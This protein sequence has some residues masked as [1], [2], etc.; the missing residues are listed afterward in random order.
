MKN[1]PGYLTKEKIYA[2][3]KT[4]VYRAIR[5]S[6]QKS[7]I[8]KTLQT[9]YPSFADIKGLKYEYQV[10]HQLN[11][12]GI[13]KVYALEINEK[14]IAI[15][16]EDFN[17]ISLKNFL[18]V[19]S[20]LLNEFLEIAIQLSQA[21]NELHQNK[22]IH[23]DI[24][25]FNIL[26]N[27]K[28]R[29]VKITDF[30][31]AICLKAKTDYHTEVNCPV[32]K[33][34]PAYI[35][36][37]QT[38]KINRPLDYRSDLYSLGITFYELLVGQLPFQTLDPLELI[39]CHISQYPTSPN[40][41]NS[42]VETVISD[43]VMKLIEK[44][45]EDRY[46][47][48]LGLK[49]DLEQCLKQY[50]S[51]GKILN[52]P[53][54]ELDHNSKFL[55]PQK[56]YGR[57]AEIA[58]LLSAFDR[59]RSGR[60]ELMLISGYSGTG[61]TAIVNEAYKSR[62]TNR[63]YFSWGK[64]EKLQRNIPY[65]AI[66]QCFRNL[67]QQILA[68]NLEQINYWKNHFLSFL[69]NNGQIIIDSIPE[70][71]LVIGPQAPALELGSTEAKN[72]F[73]QVFQSFAQAFMEPEHPLILFLDDLQWADLGSIKLIEYLINNSNNKHLLLIGAYRDNE[74]SSLHPFAQMLDSI[75]NQ[76]AIVNHIFLQPLPL[77]SVEQLVNE[78]LSIKN[79]S[80]NELVE[81]IFNKTAGNPFFINQLL[82][83]LYQENCITFNYREGAWQ[84]NIKKIYQIK[85]SDL[86]IIDLIVRNLKSLPKTTQEV[87]ALAS[88]F[89]N[90]F[91]HKNLA[92]IAK[93]REEEIAS[94]LFP[95]IQKCL[96]VPLKESYRS[97]LV[98]EQDI[99]ILSLNNKSIYQFFHDRVQQASYSLIS[100]NER[101]EIHLKIG[102]V[103]LKEN[104]NI[105][106]DESIFEITNQINIG[107]S[108]LDNQEEINELAFLNFTA[109]K[110]AKEATAYEAAKKYLD[111]C[112]NLLLETSWT[113]QY[114]FALKA[115]LLSL[116][117][118]YINADFELANKLLVTLLAFAKSQ[119]DIVQAY[120]FQISYYFTQNHPIKAIE[121]ALEVLK[122]LNINFSK[123]PKRIDILLSIFRVSLA[124]G[125][126]SISE[127]S[128][129]PIMI[130]QDQLMAMR[131]LMAVIPATFVASPKLFP[132]AISKMV[133]ISLKHG[134]S[135][136]SIF[137]YN[138][139]GTL[140]C[141]ALGNFDAGYEYSLVAIDLLEK[142]N[143]LQ[144]KSKV[145]MVFNVFN[146][147][148]KDHLNQ[149]VFML[150]EG[151]SSGLEVGDT[152]YVGHCISFLCI[153]TFLNGD[154]LDSVINTYNKYIRV[155]TE[156]KQ[157]FQEYHSNIWKQVVCN[158][159]NESSKDRL[160]LSGDS[161]SEEY[162]Y[163]KIVNHKNNLVNIAFY[164]AKSFLALLFNEFD[165]VIYF[166][167]FIVDISDD[168]PG[169][170]YIALSNFYFSIS[171]L[172]SSFNGSKMQR[173]KVLKEI[174]VQ[175]QKMKKWANNCPENFMHKYQL[176]EAEKAR[177]LGEK[178]KAIELYD[179]A[180]QS[181]A[182]SGYVQEEAIANERAAEFYFECGN[183]KIGQ[184][185]L[186]DAY[187][188]Y[189]RW[190]A[191]SK[192]KQLEERYPGVL[193][194]L[195]RSSQSTDLT[196]R[197]SVNRTNQI[198]LDL[199]SVLKASQA[200]S[201][202]IVLDELL[203]KLLKVLMQSAGAQTVVLILL[204]DQ[205]FTIEASATVHV[206]SVHESIPLASSDQVPQSVINFV[207]RTQQPIVL[208]EA[209]IDSNFSKDAY[210]QQHQVKSL[211]CLPMLSQGTLIA[212]VYLENNLAYDAFREDHLEILNL[213]CAQ[214]AIS[215]QNACLYE[216]L[217]RSQA[218]EQAERE[219]NELKSRFIS[220]TSHEFRTPLT[221]ILGT[222]ELIKHYG[223][224][225]DT[226]K[227]HTYLDRIQKNVKHMTG[228]LEDVLVLSKADQEKI[229]FNPAPI[230]LESFCQALVEELELNAKPN[231]QIEFVCSGHHPHPYA[232][233]KI[234]K[235]I[236][237]NLLSN[238]IKYSPEAS[239]VHFELVLSEEEAV[240]RVQDQ[241]IGIPK[242]DQ[243]H[244]FESFHRATNVGQIQ[245]TGLG[246][247]IVKKS[248]DLH[249]G[250]LSF[251][252]FVN[253]GTTF[254]V[255]LPITLEVLVPLST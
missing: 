44:N 157:E 116:E 246:L 187:Y 171:L 33:G 125:K 221:S 196:E 43:I 84:W 23:K 206:E 194:D 181:A 191:I 12:P 184:V 250:T 200:I 177:V 211:L 225:W 36:P 219:I 188:G 106:L 158:L 81:L 230:N 241:G 74:V 148:W 145:Y 83:T 205:N 227:Q 134:N 251:E 170:I 64:F 243:E 110:K 231:Q 215:L 52:F 223:Q 147:P 199:A 198:D 88:C 209:A 22:I 48:A 226:A 78:T 102:K 166:S 26:I 123:K 5:E 30:S 45:A 66:I 37:E 59:V 57:S 76:N 136:Y 197:N 41:L 62:F 99:N 1:F 58:Q 69:G 85:V 115:H 47:S 72:R 160:D 139:F 90:Q 95:A 80:A 77:S 50:T 24:N 71:E 228:L 93:K 63:S 173:R 118:A 153:Y 122:K 113:N 135:L 149:S 105:H 178:Y 111:I 161:F 46:Q 195:Q 143:A 222:T 127:L 131:I 98:I 192:V 129:L 119:T 7:V 248:V 213:L 15:V 137:A 9:E 11:I 176:V 236:L 10:S 16:Q 3:G 233:E 55:I 100:E 97:D 19:N 8:L 89:G 112:I 54:G 39:H 202:E 180:I 60:A 162:F 255:K 53:L 91:S 159:L 183:Q 240:F 216:D 51:K 203:T 40:Q 186:A 25:P 141:G 212:I 132:I 224:N 87:L 235:Q 165:K 214:A 86:S 124:K 146:R 126:R 138:S 172:K 75:N 27:S 144:L 114:E 61:K 82:Q 56:L 94:A 185:Y 21:L 244:L 201:E 179:L 130:D 70:L 249:K 164:C 121:T 229:N 73:N 150:T 4:S 107:I 68:E 232:D 42:K 103:L 208:G 140:Q 128:G 49:A 218:N 101:K 14:D 133:E 174:T 189:V 13:V 245:G 6:D 28:T 17:G 204:R 253:Q 38:G 237:G 117:V 238:A 207:A 29:Q 35:S 156:S 31:M 18:K 67:L 79:Q 190:G 169:L 210:I 242:A 163:S 182:R 104:S 234:L 120:E 108:L 142:L 151:I 220:M 96:L 152:E 167:D 175:Q 254:I 20:I 217:K 155:L 32:L 2:G 239:T 168:I 193:L 92:I 252:S 109:G 154:N 65:L 247:A 34:T